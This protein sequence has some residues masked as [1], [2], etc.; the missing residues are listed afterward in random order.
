MTSIDQIAGERRQRE[1]GLLQVLAS[2]DRCPH[3]RHEGDTCYGWTPDRP[4][5]GCRGGISLG[6]PMLPTGVRVGTN[7]YGQTLRMPPRDRRGDPQAW[8]QAEVGLPVLDW[9]SYPRACAE[10]TT[11][12]DI[13]RLSLFLGGDHDS[14]TGDLLRLVHK[15]QATW[16]NFSKLLA[17]FPYQVTAWVVWQAV[18]PEITAGRL[19]DLL[20]EPKATI[21][22]GLP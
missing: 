1:S 9:S 21:E 20:S 17:A 2:L 10:D 22:L 13:G 19:R 15:A 14:F 18:T 7:L 5:A 8:T 11:I 6:N 16:P 12:A 4:D 3:G